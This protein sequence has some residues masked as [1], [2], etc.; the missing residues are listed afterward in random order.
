MLVTTQ[1]LGPDTQPM[2]HFVI[3]GA[4]RR[5]GLYLTERFLALDWQVTALTRSPSEQLNSLTCA[6]L[7]V[8]TVD[9]L[10]LESLALITEK[11]AQ[12][13]I[14]LLFHN[15]SYFAPDN[16]SPL[17]NHVQL[18]QMLMTHIALPNMLNQLFASNLSQSANANIIHM[19]D[20]YVENP[21][22]N[23]ANYCASKA[24]LENLSKSFVKKLAP[25][26]RVNTIQ[27][28]ALMF[29][30]E[31]TEAA[32]KTVLANSLLPIEAG[33]E[34]ILTTILFLL[35]NP[36]VTGTSIKVDGGRAICR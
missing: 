7:S 4:S 30:P 15:A 23:Y 33:F 2:P 1:H 28:G 29:L 31:H 21:N 11:I 24:G 14:D 22:A 10:D 13:T 9:Y 36:F 35:A 20:I 34:P 3:T 12:Q 18:Q 6:N 27:P 19:P 25:N 17:D 16:D 8:I 32:K 26:V 5:L